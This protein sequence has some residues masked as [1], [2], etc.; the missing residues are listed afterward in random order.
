MI[1]GISMI[2]GGL[3][4]FGLGWYL[5]KDFLDKIH[6]INEPRTITYSEKV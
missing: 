4:S 5:H 3:L 6:K 1:I 2:V